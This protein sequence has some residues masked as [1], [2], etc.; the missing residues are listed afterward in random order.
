MLDVARH[1]LSFYQVSPLRIEL[2]GDH[3]GFSG[4]SL[5]LIHTAASDLC[6]KAW[7]PGVTDD[8]F[9][10]IHG[11]EFAARRA[12]LDFVPVPISTRAADR[13]G[14]TWASYA[15]RLWDLTTWQ[16]GKADFRED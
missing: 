2:L 15:G 14:R 13:T 6:L 7:P 5:F 16:P 3:G 12:G 11:L 8:D 9:A 10:S 1:V 4:A